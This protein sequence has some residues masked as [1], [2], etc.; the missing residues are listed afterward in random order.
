M[1]KKICFLWK[2]G[3]LSGT[4]T[5]TEK[6]KAC[7]EASPG[8]CFPFD[9]TGKSRL[10]IDFKNI[11]PPESSCPSIVTVYTQ[12][13]EFS[14]FLRDV[15]MEYPM[16][17]PEYGVI[18]TEAEDM[19]DY[20]TIVEDI[21]K[22]GRVKLLRQ[23]ENNPE[24]SFARAAERTKDIPAD[25]ALGIS[26]D[27]R[28]FVLS[29]QCNDA[30]RASQ[31]ESI[32][33]LFH[34]NSVSYKE[35]NNVP[36]RYNFTLGKGI[37]CRHVM[38]RRL[39]DG[40]LPILHA[41]LTEDCITYKVTAFA[42]LEKNPLNMIRGTHSEA[43]SLLS[44]GYDATPQQREQAEQ[45]LNQEKIEWAE[46]ETV[47]YYRV[48]A[49]NHGAAPQYAWFTLPVPNGTAAPSNISN[50]VNTSYDTES[51]FQILSDTGRVF[52]MARL[53]GC[54]A[55][56]EEMAVLIKPGH[57]A[58]LEI[59]L[60]HSPISHDRAVVLADLDFE[61]KR[62]ECHVFWQ[63]ELEKSVSV[64]LP[65]TRIDEMVHAG[66]IHLN[67]VCYGKEPDGPISP[68][69]GIP[70]NCIATESAPIILYFESLGRHDLARRCLEH[71]LNKQR[72]DGSIM[73]FGGYTIE[74]GAA[75]FL[76]CE[77]Y[78][79]TLDRAWAESVLGKL[80]CVY[81]YLVA[82]IERNKKA[83]TPGL[84]YGML[85]GKTADPEDQFHSFMLNGYGY[86]GMKRFAELLE[87]LGE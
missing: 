37:G 67:L 72:P 5:I 43:A 74:T 1:N 71:F 18:V 59:K 19:R 6:S 3:Q 75:L 78:R 16:L 86:L 9:G 82:W 84:G 28:L 39:E 34:G 13:F 24:N 21:R 65:E 41:E 49:V 87:A 55:P 54:P 12:A 85:D 4:A 15:S 52:S 26:R 11:Q 63:N 14:F 56:S 10:E 35:S 8:T 22:H 17:V 7:S 45:C 46:E 32:T 40:C 47:L 53:D 27:V 51:G 66:F 2:N 60:P 68:S 58:T 76:L 25:T 48:K 62:Q 36:V 30:A 81:D 57:C 44:A 70:Y 80:F 69:V 31:F 29:F 38:T 79:Y 33:P 77:H 61:Q 42:V 73:T 83:G 23:W 50:G 20:K 64:F